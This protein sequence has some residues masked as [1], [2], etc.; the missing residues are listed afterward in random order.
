MLTETLQFAVGEY[1]ALAHASSQTAVQF[2]S[3][4]RSNS[5]N[6]EQLYG[7]QMSAL[8]L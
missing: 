3:G 5:W 1:W 6:L 2:R 8:G 4:P 7:G